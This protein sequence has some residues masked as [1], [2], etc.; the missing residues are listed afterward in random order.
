[1]EANTNISKE[2]EEEEEEKGYFHIY[3]RNGKGKTTE[4]FSLAVRALMAGKKV[5]IGQFV[6]KQLS[7]Y[8][9]LSA[10]FLLLFY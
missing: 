8:K 2:E 3:T 6:N 10:Y 1:M 5:C 9:R 4:A 7:S